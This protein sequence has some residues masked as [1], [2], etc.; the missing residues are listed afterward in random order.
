MEGCE[1]II[2]EYSL[3]AHTVGMGSKGCVIFSAEPIREYRDYCTQDPPRADRPGVALPH[4]PRHLHDAGP[5]RGVDAVGAHT[6]EHLASYLE[7]FELFA[8]DV[9]R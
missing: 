1:R 4:E 8:R 9:T 7:A 2:G 3:P 5:G 6:D